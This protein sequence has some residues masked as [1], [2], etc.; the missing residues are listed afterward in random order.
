MPG[1][2]APPVLSLFCAVKNF[3]FLRQPSREKQCAALRARAQIAAEFCHKRIQTILFFALIT[4]TT[5]RPALSWII[6]A[7]IVFVEKKNVLRGAIGKE[8][9]TDKVICRVLCAQKKEKRDFITKT[10]KQLYHL[11]YYHLLMLYQLRRSLIYWVIDTISFGIIGALFLSIKKGEKLQLLFS[12]LHVLPF[13]IC[14]CI[15]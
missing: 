5:H 1:A 13:S 9:G 3:L 11:Y 14:I 6:L 8:G 4:I 15:N 10:S 7:T 12:S 2:A